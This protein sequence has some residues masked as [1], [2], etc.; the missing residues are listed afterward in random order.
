M[1]SAATSPVVVQPVRLFH[2]P[3]ILIPF[4]IDLNQP[5][6]RP[7]AY[8]RSYTGHARGYLYCDI[9]LWYALNWLP[10]S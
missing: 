8:M 3:L 6:S 5:A 10:F 9:F 2:R 7:P 4:L 1:V